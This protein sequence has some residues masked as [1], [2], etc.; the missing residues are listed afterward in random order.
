MTYRIPDILI[1]WDRDMG[2]L[3]QIGKLIIRVYA[4]EHCPHTFMPSPLISRH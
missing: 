1:A 4:N 3:H 2:K